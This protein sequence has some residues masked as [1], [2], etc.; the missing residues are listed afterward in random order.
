MA[1]DF[2]ERARRLRNAVEPVAAGVYFAP[3]AHTAYEALGFEGSPLPSSDGIA[4]P[5]LKS[6]FTSRGACMGHVPGEVIAAAFGV[7]NP[8]FV[9]PGIA[10]GWQITSRAAI[11]EARE[12]ASTAM[13]QRIL[14]EQPD[15]LDR[16]T[17][18]LRRAA[19]AA[20]WAGRGMY[21]GLRSLGFPANPMGAMW[22]AADLVREHR[23]DSHVI[24]WAVGGADA[25]EILLLTEQWWGL[26]ARV[27]TPSRGWSDA[28]MDAGFARLQRRGLMTDDEQL[29]DAGRA[30]REEIEV[31][32]D[33]LERPIIDALGDD[34]DELLEHL[35]AWSEAIIAG[36]SYPK[37]IAGVYNTGGG[38]HFGSGLTIDTAAQLH[39]KE[40]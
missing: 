35:D 25:V 23:G 18:L 24:S 32:T 8:K 9:V 19:D 38:P 33:E 10:A 20:P 31:R 2:Q 21:G 16:V 1:S 22:R 7:F 5:E 11:L 37:R 34:L 4:R 39:K 27:Y 13:M 12:K 14:G 15:G 28:D 30:F 26:P 3:E 40:A 6:Y 17:A 29:T 36:G